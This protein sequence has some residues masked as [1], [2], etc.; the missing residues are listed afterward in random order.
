MYVRVCEGEV[1]GGVGVLWAL[2]RVWGRSPNSSTHAVYVRSGLV[3]RLVGALL[4]PCTIAQGSS[5]LQPESGL[6]MATS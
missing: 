3:Y 5:H 2:G 4:G 6:R 1:W